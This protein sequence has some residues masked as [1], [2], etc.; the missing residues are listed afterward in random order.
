MFANFG[1]K[2]VR[3][4]FD[5]PRFF[6]VRESLISICERQVTIVRRSLWHHFRQHATFLRSIAELSNL[7]VLVE[8]RCH[9]MPQR[10]G[11][12]NRVLITDKYPAPCGDER[13]VLFRSGN[14]E[15]K[16]L[17]LCKNSLAQFTQ[18]ETAALR[19][20]TLPDA[21]LASTW[22]CLTLRISKALL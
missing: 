22:S 15:S 18:I 13:N 20:K 10:G 14:S 9:C 19:S 2:R 3:S 5:V 1:L 16:V 12:A 8:V 6:L 7:S 21:P 11:S 17:A 4:D